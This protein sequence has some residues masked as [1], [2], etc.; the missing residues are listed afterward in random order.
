MTQQELDRNIALELLEYFT[1]AWIPHSQDK[2]AYFKCD[3]PRDTNR[4]WCITHCV[5]RQLCIEALGGG[6]VVQFEVA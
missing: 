2:C 5:V 6:K 4:R 1:P 3:D